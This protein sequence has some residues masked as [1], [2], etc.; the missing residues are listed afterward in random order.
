LSEKWPDED[1]KEKMETIL[2]SKSFRLEMVVQKSER[3][4]QYISTLKSEKKFLIT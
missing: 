3:K 2:N 1:T 4:T